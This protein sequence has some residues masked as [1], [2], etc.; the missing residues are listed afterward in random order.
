MNTDIKTLVF[1]ILAATV[2]VAAF[3]LGME[4]GSH[5]FSAATTQGEGLPPMCARC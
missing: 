5:N 4:V 1:T 2:G 3:V